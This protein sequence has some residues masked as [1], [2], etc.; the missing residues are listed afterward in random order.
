MTTVNAEPIITPKI[1]NH[2]LWYFSHDAGFTP[3]GFFAAFY[4]LAGRA[5]KE[6]LAKLAEGFP[7]EVAA[8]KLGRNT[9]GG[10]DM[11]RVIA[12]IS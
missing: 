3:G 7:A 8:F 2:V 11:L 1:A 6:N 10:L 5:D 9:V 4:E 12:K